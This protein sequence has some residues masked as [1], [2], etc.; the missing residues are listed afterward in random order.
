[1]GYKGGFEIGDTWMPLIKDGGYSPPTPT[2]NVWGIRINTLD[3][4]PL[5][6][7]TLTD[8]N[9]NGP[10]YGFGERPCVFRNG[11]VQ[12]Y[13]NPNNFNQREDGSAVDITSG[14]DGDVMIEIPKMAFLIATEGTDTVIKLTNSKD[15]KSIDPRFRYYG[16][17]RASEGDRE[18]LYMGA[19][20]AS[21]GMRSLPGRAPLVSQTIGQFRSAAKAHGAGYDQLSFYPMT[22]T[23]IMYL[24]KY[25][26]LD[27][28][29]ALGVGVARSPTGAY[30]NPSGAMNTGGSET[31]GMYY[32]RTDIADHV[33]FAVIENWYGN[34]WQRFD[35]IHA[36]AGQTLLTAF[37]S[38]ND[39]GAGYTSRG[40]FPTTSSG[41]LREPLGTTEGGFVSGNDNGS[42]TTYYCN[43]TW[44]SASGW[45]G[46]LFGGSWNAAAGG[47]GAFFLSLS[48]AAADSLS[49]VG[50]RLMFL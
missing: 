48:H 3:S 22:L 39:T 12:Y 18:K 14:A 8:D 15:A 27:S 19:Y 20:L 43:Y 4:N 2:Y 16:H 34:M 46:G 44:T 28:K 9:L 25:R 1:M 32:G 50:S 37:D 10:I 35:G 5:T 24:M 38:F 45:V 40:A 33:K 17:T 29:T 49:H 7:V 23:Q 30:S 36:G 31:H 42:S 6:C 21:T 41:W 26:N 11:E 13:L 47:V